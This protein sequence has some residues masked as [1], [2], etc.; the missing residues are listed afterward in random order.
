[1]MG[2][3]TKIIVRETKLWYSWRW[4]IDTEICL[5]CQQGYD[6][7]CHRCI[8]P[9]DCAPCVGVCGHTFHS[10]CI[11]EWLAMS[12]ECPL[13]RKEWIVKR[14]F[15]RENRRVEGTSNVFIL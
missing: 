2:V 3:E 9:I 6:V 14:I 12:R 15:K 5:I 7:A 1:M 4:K 10:H 11:N 13:C 8:H